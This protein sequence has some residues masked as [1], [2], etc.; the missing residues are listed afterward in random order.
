MVRPAGAVPDA[1]ATARAEDERYNRLHSLQADFVEIYHGSGITRSESGRLWLKKP[2]KMRWEYRSPEQKLFVA[3][4]KTAWLYLTAEKQ[5]RK[6][7]LKQL[8]DL[9]SP[10][11]F[12]LGK[13]KLKKELEGL[14]FAPEM[15]V[16]MPGDAMLRGAPRGMEDRVRQVLLEITP[17]HR[18]ARIIIDGSDDSITEY[19]FSN[20]LEDVAMPEGS[21]HFAPPPG[22][23]VIEAEPGQ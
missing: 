23:E 7:S 3:D 6:S 9:R 8:E 17:E 18:I 13:T 11:A 21:F 1:D 20:L 19:R 15:T 12:L 5:V 22:S 4:G 14:A 16:W 10:L 2:G